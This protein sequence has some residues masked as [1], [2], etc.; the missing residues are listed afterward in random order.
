MGTP[1]NGTL[2][3]IRE[4]LDE[5][6]WTLYKLAKESDITCSSITSMF[7]KNT[8]PTLFT[9][10]KICHGL[11]ISVSEFFDD[12]PEHSYTYYAPDEKELIEIYR[13]VP[14]QEKEI[15]MTYIKG[16]ARKKL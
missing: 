13:S 9:L 11:G 15:L 14:E 4:L 12:A 3:R 2:I 6:G 8:Q 5:R 10:E 16:Y 1:L 7:Q